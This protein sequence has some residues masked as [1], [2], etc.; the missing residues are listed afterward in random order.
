MKRY[1]KI[2]GGI[3]LVSGTI[4]GVAILAFPVATG[5]AGFIPSVFLFFLYWI[6]MT[7]TAFCMLEVNLW[8]GKTSN[9]V[10]MAKHTLG[11]GGE[12]VSWLAYLFLMYA[13][14]TAYIAVG[15][16][17][18]LNFLKL[19]MDVNLPDWV[20]CIPVVLFFGFFVYE[21]TRYV[22]LVN[23]VLMTG[24]VITYCLMTFYLTPHVDLE[25]VMR[26]DWI[27]LPVAFSVVSTSFGFQIIIPTL[28]HYLN[29][30]VSAL[31]KVIL[32]GSLIPLVVYIIWEFFTL[33]V[34]PL[35]GENGIIQGYAR[36]EDGARLLSSVINNPTLTVIAT[37]FS[38]F[39]II[40]S[41]LGVSISLL[42]F[43]ADGLKIKK[44]SWGKIV[45]FVLTFLPPFFFIVTDPRAFFSALD[46]A[47]GFGVVI[48][49]GLLPTLMVWA[50]RYHHRFDTTYTAPGGKPA[51]IAAMLFSLLLIAFQLGVKLGFIEIP[52]MG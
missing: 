2:I 5:M 10:S 8:E 17:L 36:G 37:V 1:N 51:L 46:Y 19:F 14:M 27:Y 40:T 28:S 7:Y 45:L 41:L 49:L 43:L 26:T 44:S 29:R 50:G 4:L 18:T 39:A 22:D 11:R 42:D 33:G 23:R 25:K 12:V 15:G 47:G 20:G 30:N 32:I 13:L 52:I 24:V 21:G 38:F 6:Y 31:K 35:E 34:I 48:L 3:L 16:S 9:L